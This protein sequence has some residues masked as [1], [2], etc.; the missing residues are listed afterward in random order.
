MS[1]ALM[2][3]L[4]KAQLGS[5]NRKMLAIRLGDFADDEGRGIWPTVGRLSAE[6]ELSERTVQRLLKDFVDEGLLIVV[7][8][9][10][11]RPGQATRY[12]F[13][14]K[15]IAELEGQKTTSYG[16]HH[17]TGDTVTPVSTTTERGDKSDIEGCHGDTQTIIEPLDKPLL[18]SGACAP[19]EGEGISENLSP[20]ENPQSAAFQKRVLRFCT[21]NG[22]GAGI[23]TNWDT[24]A[25]SWIMKQ[26]AKLTPDERR[27]A[28]RWRD[29]YLLDIAARKAAPM[30]VGVFLRDKCWN[31]LDADILH[32]AEQEKAADRPVRRTAAPYGKTWGAA[33]M[34]VLLAGAKP[35]ACRPSKFIEDQ[36]LQGG[37]TGE[38]YKRNWLMKA[39]YPVIVEMHDEAR[40]RRGY[41]VDE[42]YLPLA[43]HMEQVRVGSEQWVQWRNLH[44]ERGWLWF[45][46]RDLPEWIWFPAGGVAGLGAFEAVLQGLEQ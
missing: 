42:R 15:K 24:V 43:A 28:E 22:Y 40:Q 10:G 31:L 39:G 4:F 44:E 33:R 46:E 38:F 20:E 3:R 21:G 35:P 32:R 27:Q 8:E 26:F 12:D 14:M 30:A 13:N 36:I 16:C 2:S 29:A 7:A 34:A 6:T 9:G 41:V 11:G 1:I 19:D 5:A 23:W 45:D 17:D 25:P 18:S 37:E